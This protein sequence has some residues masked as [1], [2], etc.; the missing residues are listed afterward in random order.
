MK[1]FEMKSANR[2]ECQFDEAKNELKIDEHHE[3]LGNKETGR[4]C[5]IIAEKIYKLTLQ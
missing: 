3:L 2:Q 1:T 4:A 5:E